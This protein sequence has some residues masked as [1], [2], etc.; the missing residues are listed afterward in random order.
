MPGSLMDP[1]PTAPARRSPVD[2]IEVTRSTR[3][4]TAVEVLA[5]HHQTAVVVTD[6]GA[7]VG[8]VTLGALTGCGM[9]PPGPDVRVADLMDY[10]VVRIDPRAGERDTLHRYRDA[11]WESL[12][13]RHP[14]VV[15][16]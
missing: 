6:H 15:G 13:R 3:A 5:A 1:D 9:A 8:V 11:A 12:R 7:P 4:R 2:T 10:E 14:C 16:D